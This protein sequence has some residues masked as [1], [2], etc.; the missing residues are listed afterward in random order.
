MAAAVARGNSRNTQMVVF[1][2]ALAP[3]DG[4]GRLRGTK[5]KC[6][7]WAAENKHLFS[8]KE[9]IFTLMIMLQSENK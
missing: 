6:E 7:D 9:I 5:W 3:F 4:N 1:L 8:V 2:K